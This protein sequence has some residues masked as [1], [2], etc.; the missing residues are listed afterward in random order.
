MWSYYGSKSKVVDSYPKPKHGKI[1]EPFAGSARYALKWW[2]RDVLLIDKYEI[3]VRIWKYLQQC[4]AGDIRKLPEPKRGETIDRKDFDCIEQAWLMGFLVQQ[5][6]NAP[7]LTVT[8]YAESAIATQKKNI[9]AGLP[10]IKHWEIRCGGYNDAGDGEATWFID[11]PYQIGGEWYV[12]SNR[13]IDYGAL[14]EWCRTRRGQVIVCENTKADWLPFKPMKEMW[15]A[16]YKTTEAIWSNG[17]TSYDDEQQ[18][19]FA[20][21]VCL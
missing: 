20:V 16:A 15:G 3:V 5:G 19:L 9:I 21:P 2:D 4:S 13:A 18:S 1:I 10:K 6:V 14:A 7:R 8:K 12:K 17:R 11:P